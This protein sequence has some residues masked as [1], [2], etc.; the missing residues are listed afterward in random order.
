MGLRESQTEKKTTPL[1]LEPRIKEPK[2][3]VLPITPRGNEKRVRE[4]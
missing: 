4:V 3:L 2:S 1:G